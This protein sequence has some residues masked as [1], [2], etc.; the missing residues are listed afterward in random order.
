V[1]YLDE[2]N[3]L[4]LSAASVWE[5]AI[6]FAAGRLSLPERPDVF[7][8]RVR[9]VSDIRTLDID[10]ESAIHAGRLPLLHADPFDRMIVAQ[11]VIH[12]MTILTPDQAIQQYAVRVLW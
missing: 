10:E 5:I 1:S 3:E 6:K 8:P 11:A 2:D 9:E 12:G 7:V 4:Y